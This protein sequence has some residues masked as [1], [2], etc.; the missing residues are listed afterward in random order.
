MVSCESDEPEGERLFQ[1]G[2]SLFQTV[3]LIVLVPD[4]KTETCEEEKSVLKR[5]LSASAVEI[6]RQV[7]TNFCFV[8]SST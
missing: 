7:R 2:R 1:T 3:I 8:L 5:R 6:E 4:T